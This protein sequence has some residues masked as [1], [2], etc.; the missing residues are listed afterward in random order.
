MLQMKKA[1]RSYMVA[2]YLLQ[3]IAHTLVVIKLLD[4][5]YTA[6]VRACWQ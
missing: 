2:T 4:T 6:H 1:R 5:H 3:D